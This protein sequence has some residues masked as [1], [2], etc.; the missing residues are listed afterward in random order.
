M[1]GVVLGVL[2]IVASLIIAVFWVVP[3]MAIINA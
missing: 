3:Q 1:T 2:A